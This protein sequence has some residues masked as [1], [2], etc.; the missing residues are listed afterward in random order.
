M[1]PDACYQRMRDSL[2][3]GDVKEANLAAVD[4]LEWLDKGGAMPSQEDDRDE[5]VAVCKFLVYLEVH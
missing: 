1:D 4:L 2:E 5:L 3:A